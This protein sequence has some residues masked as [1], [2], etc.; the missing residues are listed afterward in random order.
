MRNIVSVGNKNMVVGMLG[1]CIDK[2]LCSIK[3]RKCRIIGHHSTGTKYE[4]GTYS[5]IL[6]EFNNGFLFLNLLNTIFDR[7][8]TIKQD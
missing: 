3:K 8:S 5:G 7:S 1:K 4:N 6:G 2:F